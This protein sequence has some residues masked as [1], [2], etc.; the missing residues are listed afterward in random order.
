LFKLLATL[1]SWFD[2]FLRWRHDQGQRD[3]GRDSERADH[4]ATVKADVAV[5]DGVRAAVADELRADP[6]ALRTPDEF[7]RPD[8]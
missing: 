6:A 3:V 5:A 1:V 8:E 7:E 2:A 4:E